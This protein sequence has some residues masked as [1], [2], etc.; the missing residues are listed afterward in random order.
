MKKA[1]AL[2]LSIVMV[3]ALIPTA[4]AAGEVAVAMD[5]APADG[6]KVVMYYPSR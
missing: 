5:A 6:D 4:F 3:F 1:L 2:I